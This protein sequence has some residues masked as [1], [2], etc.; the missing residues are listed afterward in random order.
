[1]EQFNPGLRNL[2]NLGKN[3]EK[4]VNAMILA[5]KAYYDGV[6]KIGEIASGSPVSTELGHVLIEISSTHK[7]LNDSLDENFLKIHKEIIHELEKIE[8]D[9]KHM[10]ASRGAGR[11]WRELAPESLRARWGGAGESGRPVDIGVYMWQRKSFGFGARLRKL[12]LPLTEGSARNLP[13][14]ARSPASS[15]PARPAWARWE[16]RQT[17]ARS[18]A[19]ECP[20]LR[21]C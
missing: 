20:W 14:S 2:L 4:A 10:N 18:R 5:G 6:A 9:V 13:S 17:R 16:V 1:M 21:G 7:K 11:R 15:S 12:C 19:P 3:Y 8:L